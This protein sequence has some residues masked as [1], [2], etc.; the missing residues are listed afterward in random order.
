MW[1]CWWEQGCVSGHTGQLKEHRPACGN[2]ECD[3]E[4]WSGRPMSVLGSPDSSRAALCASV[5]AAI[6]VVM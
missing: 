6:S 4:H 1:S 5:S 3:R 2:W